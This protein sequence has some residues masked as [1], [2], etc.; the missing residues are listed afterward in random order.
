VPRLPDGTV[1]FVA[2]SADH[3]LWAGCGPERGP[4]GTESIPSLLF[5]AAIAFTFRSEATMIVNRK[6]MRCA[7]VPFS[8]DIR[9]IGGILMKKWFVFIACLWAFQASAQGTYTA[10]SC[11]LTDVTNAIK[12]EQAHHVDGDII[13]IPAGNCSWSSQ[14]S[15]AFSNSVTI[16]GQGAISATSGGSST[17]GSDVTAITDNSGNGVMAFNTVAGKSFRLT[18]I[19]I[20]GASTPAGNGM[21]AIAGTSTAVRVDHC[22]FYVTNTVSVGLRL[23]GSVLGVADHDVFESPNSG[24]NN[25]LAFHNGLGWN[26][27]PDPYPA[28]DPSWADTEHWGTNKFFFVEDSLFSGQGDIGDA[29][30]GARYVL[31]YSTVATTHGQMYNHGLTDSRGRSTRAAEVYHMNFHRSVQDGSPTYSL[32]SGSMLYWGNT[33]T[34]Y[35]NMFSLDYTRKNNGTYGYGITPSGWGNCDGTGVFTAWDGALLGYPCL[36]QPGRG[37]GDLLNG[38]FFPNVSDT[39][40]G[41]ISFTHQALSPIYAWSNTFNDAGFSPEGIVTVGIPAL[42]ADNREYYQQFGT[43]GES[44]SFNGT[45]GVGQGLLSARPLTCTAGPGGNTPGVGYW[46]TDSNTLYVCNPTNIWTTYYTPYTYP[47]P[48]TQ[49]LGTSVAAPTGLVAT[50]Q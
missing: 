20:I 2:I 49:S 1:D 18:G 3:R 12:A 29:H 41:T 23:D 9:W 47:H 35:R 14:L 32:N 39:I 43:Y 44:G 5:V 31:R 4:G 25:P 48:L 17:T 36:D 19:A 45:K 6:N 21:V 28:A 50:V 11:S 33:S 7:V 27:M 34:N 30:D 40:T 8:R 10:A 22:H 37:A 42:V 38:Q 46:A 16:Q 24:A 26:G 15:A 13:S